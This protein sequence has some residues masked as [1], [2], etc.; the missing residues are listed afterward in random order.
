MNAVSK[1]C[2]TVG[3][4]SLFNLSAA[5]AFDPCDEYGNCEVSDGHEVTL[6]DGNYRNIFAEG[7]GSRLTLLGGVIEAENNSAVQAYD[8]AAIKLDSV[9]IHH[10][11]ETGY[12]YYPI[13]DLW[14]A[15]L[16]ADKVYIDV[17]GLYGTAITAYQSGL[18]LNGGSI[19]AHG[20]GMIGLDITQNQYDSVIN[21][22]ILQVKGEEAVGMY[23]TNHNFSDDELMQVTIANS[24]I[25]VE[26][27]GASAI[28][29]QGQ[30]HTQLDNV[31]IDVKNHETFIEGDEED[32]WMPP[33]P[34]SGGA[35]ASQG[36]QLT[37]SNSQIS[38]QGDASDALIFTSPF[39]LEGGGTDNNPI[40][41]DENFTNIIQLEKGAVVNSAQA[42]AVYSSSI[43]TNI[44]EV[45]D[46]ILAGDRLATLE[47]DDNFGFIPIPMLMDVNP[48]NEDTPPLTDQQS[49]PVNLLLNARNAQLS[50]ST[51]L[52]DKATL[53]M[54]LRSG[55]DWII[56]PDKAGSTRSQLS[57]LALEGSTI[58]FDPL[59]TGLY[60]SLIV[61]AG[62]LGGR[63]DVFK[64]GNN[65]RIGFNTL[66]N[67]GG[68][69]D[70]QR[71]DRLLIEGDVSGTTLIHVNE[72][73]GSSGGE[74]SPTGA[75]SADE[76]ISLIQVA[77][78]AATNS[79]ALA[80]GYITMNNQPYRYGL[81][82]YGPGSSHGQADSSQR[83]VGGTDP[84]W[85]FRLQSV[86]G[87]AGG[88]SGHSTPEIVPQ[89]AN[90]LLT[91]PLLM[92]AKFMDM[93][94]Y[95]HRLGDIRSNMLLHGDDSRAEYFMNGFH[96]HYNYRSN[97]P[98]NQYGYNADMR[99]N[100]AQWGGNIYGFDGGQSMTRI[101]ISFN[102]GR[103]N[104]A[105]KHVIGSKDNALSSWNSMAHLVW[106][107]R[108]G[109]YIDALASYGGFGG[110]V[111]SATHSNTA[112]IG[113]HSLG[114]SVEVGM[115]IPLPACEVALEPQ[116]QITYLQLEFD[117]S[118]DEADNFDLHLGKQEQWLIRLGGL[119]SRKMINHLS[120]REVSF[121]AKLNY[122][123]ALKNAGKIWMGDEFTLGEFGNHIEAGIGFNAL[124]SDTA[125]IYGTLAWQERLDGPGF[126]GVRFNC[127][128]RAQF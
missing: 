101:G 93:A 51:H 119:L 48:F 122:I 14:Q 67:E 59:Q 56:H 35:F 68:S 71:T 2:L 94:T 3:I 70:N 9:T 4:V 124:L 8:G 117:P 125:T 36:G 112:E 45:N 31:G 39:Y 7:K 99:Y 11:N 121:H 86:F 13:I 19:F 95:F 127:G 46:S 26:G 109:L 25:Q 114:A 81:Y 84:Y 12:I 115:E 100:M 65:A 102:K 61:G 29:V 92:Q 30:V 37:L 126:S 53:T 55:T 47:S 41:T 1:I 79:F 64:A 69:L 104:L 24:S 32:D 107:H 21:D 62:E 78:A 58:H 128:V 43:D 83:L 34:H 54:N 22:L 52:D 98:S 105:P 60:Q 123:H 76:G 97:L 113:G 40:R 27:A 10:D 5:H 66:L 116:I 15:T 118:R 91:S 85:D 28:D 88:G 6:E 106:L 50:G 49:A 90:Y 38:T 63:R 16:E 23:I 57:F 111:K 42:S 18:Q 44:V 110:N 80:G 103:M 87:S 89:A 17:T 73:A 108:S 82:A 75:Y 20:K 74:T 120:G 96:L 72:M 77:G 33:V